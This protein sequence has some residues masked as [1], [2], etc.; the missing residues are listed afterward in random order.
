MK[1]YLSAKI[2][3]SV[4]FFTIIVS[5]T[6]RAKN[7][8]EPSVPK[9]D[10][11][12]CIITGIVEDNSGNKLQYV[13][14]SLSK[15]L[16]N[17]IICTSITDSNGV[18][19]LTASNSGN[20]IVHAESMGYQPDKRK[21]RITDNSTFINIGLIKISEGKLLGAVTVTAKVA[22]ITY[23]VN[24]IT[25][26]V[27]QD[28]DRFKFNMLRMMEKVPQIRVN[29][30]G[31]IECQAPNK[32]YMIL[33]NGKEY[34]LISSSRQFPMNFINADYM[35]T[36]EVIS[37]APPEYSNVDAVINIILSKPLPDGYA[38]ETN[39]SASTDNSY[40]V[41]PGIVFKVGKEIF[42][43][44]YNLQTRNPEPL[45]QKSY[46]ENF[47]SET[48]RYTYKS[49]SKES[50]STGN[51]ISLGGSHEFRDKKTLS[52][53][54]ST[55]LSNDNSLSKNN[56]TIKDISGNIIRDITS[57]N[58]FQTKTSPRINGGIQ[59]WEMFKDNKGFLS[60]RY[61]LSNTC[62]ENSS[63]SMLDTRKNQATKVKTESIQN[64]I[65]CLFNLL[66]N[67][68]NRISINGSYINRQYTNNSDY[69]NYEAGTNNII[70]E[71]NGLKYTQQIFSAWFIYLFTYNKISIS[72]GATT[73]ILN[74]SGK[75]YNM[76]TASP[77]S[78]NNLQISPRFQLS[79]KPSNKT[80]FNF[81][82]SN[83][84][85][86]PGINLLNPY[87]NKTDPYNISVGNPGLKSEITH[88]A[89]VLSMTSFING[90]LIC[91]IVSDLTDRSIERVTKTDVGNVNLTTYEN[92]G[93]KKR[94]GAA[95]ELTG[96]YKSLAYFIGI[97]G[98]K[99][100]YSGI[101]LDNSNTTFSGSF[102]LEKKIW[103]STL[104]SGNFSL[105]T[106]QTYAQSVKANLNCR[107]SLSMNQTI[108]KDRLAGGFTVSNPFKNKR[109]I[110]NEMQSDNFYLKDQ[111]QEAG[112][113]IKFWVRFNFGH[114]NK[115]VRSV[116]GG[117]TDDIKM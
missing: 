3:L 11:L 82:Y 61:N 54:L 117:V 24:K 34:R 96:N 87:I 4:I 77:L 98:Y 51:S 13:T 55:S 92:I 108:I 103:K 17:K 88:S 30:E 19:I 65:S 93:S 78:Y 99:N 45:E 59:Y 28:P 101:S 75:F 10:S 115:K 50:N 85:S 8:N 69:F 83:K 66:I 46:Q 43:L 80:V 44:D 49:G 95:M 79:Y 52:F 26:D 29:A 18:F 74:N 109:I 1:N 25:Y 33:V 72:A 7:Q 56:I 40:G 60:I 102:N 107:Y 73:E 41:K 20:F 9:E 57:G 37:P 90:F 47:L 105:G 35:K 39:L 27:Q 21:V 116:E 111:H 14:L 38:C 114:F 23:E 84:R 68:K 113:I 76:G 36:I 100:F 106:N 81:Y 94:V 15:D 6:A 48:N 31:K 71:T 5:L 97:E 86:N 63:F 22:L 112:R 32:S 67:S 91:R 64:N 110:I 16:E 62:N 53:S 42:S 58:I 89:S 12:R 70:P 2:R 104:I